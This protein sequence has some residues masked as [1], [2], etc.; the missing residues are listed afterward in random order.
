MASNPIDRLETACQ[1]L[2]EFESTMLV[3]RDT[4]TVPIAI[5][6]AA[7]QKSSGAEG[8]LGWL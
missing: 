7:P 3:I 2:P 8:V 4:A 5:L 6:G 1:S